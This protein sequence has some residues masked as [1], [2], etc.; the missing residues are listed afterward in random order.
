MRRLLA[1]TMALSA[2][3]FSASAE[4]STGWGLRPFIGAGYTW[5]GDTIQ[6]WDVTRQ[7]SG[8]SYED[9]VSAGAG[10]DLRLGLS[11]RLGQLPL[12]L[13]ASVAHHIDQVSGLDGRGYFRRLPLE[14]V[15]QWH[16]T[17]RLRIGMG[18]R[19]S[20]EATLRRTG[21]T[22]GSNPCTDYRLEMES[23]TGAILEAEYLVTPSW[24]LKARYV[25]ENYRFKEFPD[26]IKFEGDHIGLMTN[27]YFN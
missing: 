9:D 12:T 19:R 11:Y 27:Y 3:H 15:V 14:L 4:E 24:G 25:R 13:Q 10:L 21:G 7:G 8:S 5:G 1:L 2:A 18:M 6:R 23:S 16:A 20:T 26:A 17:D 22:C